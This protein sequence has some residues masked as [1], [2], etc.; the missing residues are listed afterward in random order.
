MFDIT[1]E[2]E[3]EFAEMIK[4]LADESTPDTGRSALSLDEFKALCAEYNVGQVDIAPHVKKIVLISPVLPDE[5]RIVLSRPDEYE[6]PLSTTTPGIYPLREYY[7]DAYVSLEK[8]EMNEAEMRDFRLMR[9]GEY[10]T[11]KCL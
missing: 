7:D 2:N 6:I 10:S 8:I 5:A 9:I 4:A 1:V 3:R 11:S